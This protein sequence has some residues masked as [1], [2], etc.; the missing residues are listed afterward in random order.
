MPTTYNKSQL[1]IFFAQGDIPS[2]TD[3]QNLIYSQVNI[4]ETAQQNMAGPLYTTKLI[5]PLMSANVFNAATFSTPGAFAAGSVSANTMVINTQ[6]VI[7]NL[8]I[9]GV[10]SANNL[11]LS[12]VQSFTNGYFIATPTI[13][14]AAGIAIGTAAPLSVL[15][16][17]RG[18]GATDGSATGFGLPGNKAGLIQFFSY[19]GTVS[20]N[21]W[22]AGADYKINALA[23]GAPF[24][25]AANTPYTILHKTASAYAVK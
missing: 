18:Q 6:A 5:T 23:S 4:V 16:F 21:L 1:S 19:E 13:T 10:T 15:N 20:A 9:A 12:G 3:Y 24:P 14:S 7:G 11:N 2:G 25:L 22:P 8:T 17:V